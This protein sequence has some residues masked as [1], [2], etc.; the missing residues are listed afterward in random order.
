[1]I[2]SLSFHIGI[3][4]INKFLFIVLIASIF[5]SESP[6]LLRKMARESRCNN[7]TLQQSSKNELF[8]QAVHFLILDEYMR[9]HKKCTDRE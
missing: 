4:S 7:F 6:L 9:V 3:V 8:W 5:F 1:M 2:I